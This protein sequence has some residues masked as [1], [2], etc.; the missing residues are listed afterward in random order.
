M[1]AALIL[2]LLLLAAH[3][4]CDYPLQ[5]DFLANAKASGPLRV[6]HLTAHTGIHGGAVALVTGSLALGLVEWVAHAVID[7]LKV[8]KTTT[9]AIDQALHIVCKVSY[10]A[11]IVGSA[12]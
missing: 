9:F 6:Y 7:E 12:P 4:V 2:L 11:I 8:R 1:E 10:V 5:G 3:W